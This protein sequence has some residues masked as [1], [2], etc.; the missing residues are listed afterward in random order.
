LK[1]EELKSDVKPYHP[2][3]EDFENNHIE[4]E[5]SYISPRSINDKPSQNPSSYINMINCSLDL[6]DSKKG[7]FLRLKS[8]ACVVSPKSNN[9]MHIGLDKT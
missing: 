7:D 5:D 3:K 4:N 8:Q 2:L 6:R 9:K 1:S